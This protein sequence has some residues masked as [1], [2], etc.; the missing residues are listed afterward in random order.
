MKTYIN[1]FFCSWYSSYIS[2][3]ELFIMKGKS[4]KSYFDVADVINFNFLELQAL[5]LWNFRVLVGELVKDLLT[6]GRL[7][8]VVVGITQQVIARRRD[9]LP[10]NCKMDMFIQFIQYNS[11]MEMYNVC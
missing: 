10:F 4:G 5:V 2:D 1:Y 11:N 7:V 8:A 9:A 6:D 3:I